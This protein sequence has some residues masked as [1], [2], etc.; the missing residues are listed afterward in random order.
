MKFSFIIPT[1]NE[2]KYLGECLRSI[3]EQSL[4][5]YEVIVVDRDSTDRTKSIARKYGAN[6]INE[7]RRGVGLARNTGAA[8]SKGRILIFADADARLDRDFLQRV[9]NKFSEGII[10]G[11]F[12]LSIYD[13]E[14]VKY[15]IL[16]KFLNHLIKFLN[17]VGINVTGGSCL[18]CSRSVFQEAGGFNEKLLNNDDHD[19]AIKSG[20]LGKFIFFDDII[21]H[22]SS[23]RVK[24]MGILKSFKVYTKS[25]LLYFFN[26]SYLRDY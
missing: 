26:N 15:V 4:R 18:V 16:Y 6:V 12:R 10:G 14:N 1:R 20:K 3:R 25:I 13:A 24:K 17:R 23:R 2:G 9:D 21:V 8:I 22:T 5:S 19:M 11:V 7:P